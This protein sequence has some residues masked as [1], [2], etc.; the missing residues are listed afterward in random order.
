MSTEPRVDRLAARR[1]VHFASDWQGEK[2]LI[3]EANFRSRRR[4]IESRLDS[5][6]DQEC[7][8]L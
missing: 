4:N 5:P 1:A 2:V 7:Q 3:M 8:R 6:L